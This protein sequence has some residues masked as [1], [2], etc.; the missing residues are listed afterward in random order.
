MYSLPVYFFILRGAVGTSNSYT[1]SI[2]LVIEATGI[3]H[4][5]PILH[6]APQNCFSGPT[7]AALVVHAFQVSFLLQK[8]YNDIIRLYNF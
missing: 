3:A 7:V 2:Q 1:Y 6:P 8:Q 5:I 4:R